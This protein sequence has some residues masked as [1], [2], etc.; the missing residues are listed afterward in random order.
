MIAQGKIEDI[1]NDNDLWKWVLGIVT[2]LVVLGVGAM[3]TDNRARLERLDSM[4][5]RQ[6]V[7]QAQQAERTRALEAN[8][9]DILRRLDRIDTKLDNALRP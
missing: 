6:S 1:L 3:T 9:A 7:V 4:I 8:Y 2:A 5:D